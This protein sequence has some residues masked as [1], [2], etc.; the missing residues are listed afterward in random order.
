MRC[1]PR[2]PPSASP[3]SPSS[4][5]RPSGAVRAGRHPAA[6]PA[7]RPRHHDL[8][9][10]DRPR[11]R[12]QAL[13]AVAAEHG[14]RGEGGRARRRARPRARHRAD[15]AH[16]RSGRRS[17]LLFP[18]FLLR[19]RL[20]ASA[21]RPGTP[22]S[23]RC[24]RSTTPA[25]RSTATTSSGSS[26]DP[27]ICLPI[28]R[29]DHPRRPRLSRDHAAAQGV[30]A[31]AALVDEH[32]ARAAGARL[33]CSSPAPSTSPSSSGTTPR[34]SARSTL[35]A[36][37]LA[38]FFQSVQTRTA[39]FNSV[40]IGAMHDETW[41]GM[42]VLMFIGG[43]PAGT[44]GGIKV[45][46]FAVLFFIMI[47]E[48]RGEGAVNIFGKRLSRA[49]HRQ[50]IT[51]VL[52]AVAAVIVGTV[53]LMLITGVDLDRIALR[54]GLGVRHG[55]ALDRHHGRPARRGEA[56]PRRC[57]C[58]SAG[59]ARSRSVRRSPCASAASSTSTRRRGPPLARFPILRRADTS[60]RIAEADS[61][62]VIGLGRFGSSL[63]LELMAGGT[64][65]LGIDVDEDIVQ[66]LNGQLTQVVRA[67]STKEEALRQLAV[68]EFDRVVVAIGDDISASILTCSVLLE[69][70]DPG[71]LGEGRR[72]PARPHPRA[73]RRAPRHLPRE[74]HGRAVAHLVRGAALDYIE[75]E[76]GYALVKAPALD[77]PGHAARRDRAAQ[78]ARRHHRR[79]PPDGGC[80]RTPTPTRCSR[81]VTRSSSSGRRAR[82]RAS[83][84]C[85][86]TAPFRVSLH[87]SP[88]SEARRA[89][90]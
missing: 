55:R 49:V 21:R 71:H 54:G 22:C 5:P 27:F 83:R 32:E 35:A 33:S 59:S 90:A 50:A 57:S 67:D 64:E 52:I 66:A 24:R 34:R 8:R 1:S 62:A 37:V 63:A 61:V 73:A 11:A 87:L 58:S 86:D 74:G 6:D 45:T 81:R 20:R 31:P 26:S 12:P 85:A 38:G 77:D 89:A 39:G 4:T 79:V 53:V 3:A 80:G 14:G 42:D 69:H 82:P 72:R 41:L 30:P 84:S 17:L 10:A 76:Q 23:I 46:T 28:V 44:A 68:D 88:H 2:P 13:G 29:R 60:R 47:T 16:D 7:R 18:R 78:G 36:R 65:V 48:L 9:V 19:L 70:E 56:H 51:V 15:L 43:G 25:S 40:D 75:I